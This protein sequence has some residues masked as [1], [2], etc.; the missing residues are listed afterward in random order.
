[1][2]FAEAVPNAGAAQL[3]LMLS[4]K[5]ACQSVIGTRTAGLDA[6]SL[7]A[8]RIGSGVWD[9][10]IVSAGEEFCDL[11]NQA[12]CHCGLHAAAGGCAPFTGEA[13]FTMG[14][15]A[16]TFILESR[17]SFERRGGKAHGR[18]AANAAGR[19]Q[20]PDTIATALRVLSE[21]DKPAH[22]LS[23]AC[24]TWMDRAEAAAIRQSGARHVSAIYGY[25]AETFSASPLI[26]IAATL[27]A[28]KMPPLLGGAMENLPA[29]DSIHSFGV[30]CTDPT[31]SVSGVRID[32]YKEPGASPTASAFGLGSTKSVVA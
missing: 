1:M 14:A 12:Y 16:V 18:I 30:I 26:A 28:G 17:A 32:G 6:L 24:G 25:V 31:G 9:R 27:L 3:S 29:P 22:V 13:G 20:R 23:S 5:G 8:A 15:G 19:G 10:A 21:L 11:V 4:L 2:L 7:A